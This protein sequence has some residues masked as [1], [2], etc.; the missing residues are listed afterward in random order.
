VSTDSFFSR[1]RFGI[2]L[3]ALDIEL[4]AASNWVSGGTPKIVSIVRRPET[5]E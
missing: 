2:V 4:A 5:D 3:K 1:L